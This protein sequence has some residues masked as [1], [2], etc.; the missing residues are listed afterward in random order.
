MP[1]RAAQASSWCV[2]KFGGTSLAGPA[3]WTRQLEVLQR[4]LE[5]GE[6]PLLVYSAVAGTTDDLGALPEN[7]QADRLRILDRIRERHRRL[8]EA[9]GLDAVPEVE[10]QLR[11][12]TAWVGTRPA[13]P[14]WDPPTRAALLGQGELLS[15][16]LGAAWLRANGLSVRWLDARDVL[17]A[18]G[19]DTGE[20]D[21]LSAECDCTHSPTLRGRFD[22]FPEDVVL[23]QGFLARNRAGETVVLGRG[24]SDTAAAYLASLIGAGRVE[25]WTDVPGLF[26]A[27]PRAVAGARLIR[28][29][30]YAEAETLATMGAAALHPRSIAP[31][32]EAG[33]PMHIAWTRHPQFEGTVI[34]SEIGAPGVKAISSRNGLCLLSTRR[35]A[36]WQPVGF[37]ADVAGCFREHDLCMDLVSSSPSDIRATVDLHADPSAAGRLEG[38]LED[39][40]RVS[41]ASLIG[42]AASVS[43]VGR[44]IRSVLPDLGDA[45][46][47]LEGHA[48]HLLAQSAND[49]S[50]TWVTERQSASPLVEN[51]HEVL[52]GDVPAGDTFGP[53][54]SRL[55]QTVPGNGTRPNAPALSGAALR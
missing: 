21:F 29:L 11:D 55:Q 51:I 32:R 28:R 31:V 18:P 47:H 53:T 13:G 35:P 23:T 3:L 12:L 33:I 8:A 43:L 42:E 37:M 30:G 1:T 27:N 6:R 38:L 19:S 36:S 20:R 2:L 46:R 7:P 17:V 44:E 4:R 52:F 41:E 26:T 48:I 16:R 45:L 54:W 9:L 49:H 14:D 15:T 40:N 34:G 5:A 24:G 50:L 39:L 22:A 25:I 10:R